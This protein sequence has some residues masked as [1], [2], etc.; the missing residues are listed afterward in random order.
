MAVLRI[1]RA[2]RLRAAFS[3]YVA[4]PGSG[5]TY[6]TVPAHAET[7]GKRAGE[8]PQGTFR[9]AVLHAHRV[10]PVLLFA[11]DGGRHTKGEVAYWLRREVKIRK[12]PALIRFDLL[13]EEARDS[14]EEY[15]DEL[16][17]G[18]QP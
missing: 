12:D 18:G 8:F 13:A 17:R 7:Y 11:A 16:R 3:D 5:R 14:A 15:I 4:R 2:S 1:P 10:F 6:L 9:F